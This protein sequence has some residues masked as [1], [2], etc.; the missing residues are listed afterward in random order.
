MGSLLCLVQII[1]RPSG[2]YILLMTDVM[3]QNLQN[4][5]D[6]GLHPGGLGAYQGQHDHAVSI[7]KLGMFKELV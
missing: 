2:D 5:H 4:I 7:L 3:L 1:F 6:L